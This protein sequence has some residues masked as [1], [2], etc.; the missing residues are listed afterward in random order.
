MKRI[1]PLL[2]LLCCTLPS[3]TGGVSLSKSTA[4]RT[5]Q[6]GED[7]Q[8]VYVG[9]YVNCHYGGFGVTIPRGLR[10]LSNLPPAPQHGF[11]IN[12]PSTPKGAALISVEADYDSLIRGSLGGVVG[13]ELKEGGG[14]DPHFVLLK[15]LRVVS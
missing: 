4:G 8:T 12:L 10:G 11:I 7:Q 1:K 9:H 2:L 13:G 6:K 14:D 15:R 3:P 5:G